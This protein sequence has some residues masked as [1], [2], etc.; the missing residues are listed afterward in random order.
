MRQRRQALQA[1]ALFLAGVSPWPVARANSEAS[2]YPPIEPRRLV[3]PRDFGSH[4][5]YRTEW[6]YLTGWLGQGPT[7]MGFQITF[8]RSRTRHAPG[9]PSRLAPTQLLFAHAALAVAESQTFLHASRAGRMNGTSLR[10]NSQDTDLQFE[11][12]HLRRLPGASAEVYQGRFSDPGYALSLEASTDQAPLLR[13]QDGLSAKGPDPSQA[14]HYYS[15][16]PLR[17]KAQVQVGQQTR[18]LLGTAWLDHEWSSQLLMPGAVGWD[19]LGIN[20]LDGGTL[21]AFQIRNDRA[22][23]LFTHVDARGRDGQATSGWAGLAWQAGGRWRAPSL[24]EYP[25]PMD[26]RVGDALYQLVP[27]MRSQEVDAR[28]STGGYYWEGAVSLMQGERLLGQGYL[29]LTGYGEPLRL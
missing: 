1:A 12:W 13:G 27:L 4:P 9:N 22:E 28:A 11:D 23:P 24:I 14:S 10:A 29:E 7:A 26:L 15:R 18:N 2:F 20:L 6:W 21:M 5:A 17:V 19:W 25:I 16:A 3:F 8:F